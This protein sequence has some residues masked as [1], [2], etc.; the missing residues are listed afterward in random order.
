MVSDTKIC[1]NI[2]ATNIGR[3]HPWRMSSMRKYRHRKR[4]ETV[5]SNIEILKTSLESK[6]ETFKRLDEF[7]QKV[8]KQKDMK[9]YDK[10][11]VFNKTAKGYRKGIHLTHRWTK[12]T[13]RNP[14]EG[15]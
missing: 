12:K 2:C 11:F 8:P 10:Y 5:D 6:G 1:K 14:P 7:M 4:M 15:F 9:P 3:K 13:I